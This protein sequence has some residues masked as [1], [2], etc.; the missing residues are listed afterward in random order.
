MG[1]I[2]RCIRADIIKSKRTP[3]IFIHLLFPII[4]AIIF[5][6]YFHISGRTEIKN[7]STFLEVVAIVF[8][9]FVGITVGIV[10]QLESEAGDFQVMLGTLHSKITIYIGKLVYLLLLA[11]MSTILC[12]T[13][14]AVLY[15][16]VPYSFYL[17]PAGALLMTILPIYII[18]LLVGFSFGKS[19]SMSIGIVG[20]LLSAL[21][22]TGLGDFIWKFIPWGWGIRF[23]EFCI[24]RYSNQDEVSFVFDEFKTGLFLMLAITA[25]LFVISILWFNRWE[26]TK[27]ND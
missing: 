19:V 17:K 26:G 27:G 10:I 18:S 16:V 23:V 25:I 22:M 20:S 8:P 6:G 5:A 14:F 15:P 24:L 9:F 12:L 4:G 11:V 7:I 21:M 1:S 13:L 2:I 3:L